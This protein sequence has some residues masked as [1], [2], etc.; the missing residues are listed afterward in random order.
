MLDE[1]DWIR[2]V[3]QTWIVRLPKQS[4]A[5]FGTTNVKY[6]VV[7]E[8]MYEDLEDRSQEGVVRTGRV[9]AERPTIVTPTYAMNLEGFREE[10]YEYL[11]YLADTYGPNNSGLLYQYRNEVHNYD[12]VSGVTDDIAYSLSE[13]LDRR[14]ENMSVVMVGVDEYWDLALLKFAYEFTSMS[15][16][17]NTRELRQRG[18]LEPQPHLGGVPQAA[19]LRIERLFREVSLGGNPETLKRE[20]DQWGLFEYYESRFLDLF[21][22]RKSGLQ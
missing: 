22:R 16:G 10:A 20:L 1:R 3:E 13:D 15:A 9:I 17:E 19:V 21:R 2:A 7:T 5:T 14:N 4:L 8:P 6:Y 18:L 11:R 12:T